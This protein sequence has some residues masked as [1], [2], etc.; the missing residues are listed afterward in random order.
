MHY[1]NLILDF[2]NTHAVWSYIIIFL[3]S[4]SE[5]LAI[6][7]LI[8]PGS[9]IMFGVG[10]IIAAGSLDVK[11][12]IIIA[13]TGAIVG[14]GISFWAGHYYKEKI[15]KIWPFSR[16]PGLLKRG[17]NFFHRHG[18]KSVLIGR[19]VGPVRPII[20]VIA[21]TMGM[22]PL[23]F[24]IINI[25]S[26]IG[27]AFAY[28][29]PG[30]IL[31][32]SIAVIG[33][34]SIRLAIIIVTIVFSMWI[35]FTISR[36]AY[37]FAENEMPKYIES[38]RQ[39]SSTYKISGNI[40]SPFKRFIFYLFR[41]HHGEETFLAMLILI[42]VLALWISLGIIQ[43]VLANDPIVQADK[44]VYHFFNSIRVRQI[45]HIF[46]AITEI[47]DSFINICITITVF[48]VL[49]IKRCFRTS[50]LWLISF[51]GALFLVQTLK[52]IMHLPRPIVL[53]QGASAYSFPS[54][55][56]T[57]SI[58]IFGFLC[59]LL[60]RNYHSAFKWLIFT[61]ALF[62]TFSIALSR[63]YLGVHWLS[64]VLGGFFIGTLWVALMGILY[65]K[66][67]YE[68]IPKKLLATITLSVFIIAGCWHINNNIK[69]D[70]VLYSLRKETKYTTFERWNTNDWSNL[71]VWRVDM[72][73]ER[74]QPLNF[75]F[76][77]EKSRLREYLLSKGW[78]KPEPIDFKSL[79]ETL[80]SKTS[81]QKLPVFPYLNS[82]EVESL[83]LVHYNGDMRTVFRMWDSDTNIMPDNITIYAGM[84][85]IQ[86]LHNFS[87]LLNLPK[88]THSYD[89]SLQFLKNDLT[90]HY[91][92]KK[93][94]RP[95]Y[96][97]YQDNNKLKWKGHILL[98][99]S[100]NQKNS[101][102]ENTKSKG[103]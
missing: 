8:M 28:I 9:T 80:S 25:I 4:F 52:W 86:Q 83:K 64:D 26:A 18:G 62:I 35:L 14:D 61:G 102:T 55:H 27:W 2:I 56:T 17:G 98:I 13:I 58:V 85:E 44:A 16:Y 5:S 100:D 40:L 3:V 1:I 76:A 73:G 43:D 34:I 101:I 74:E 90:D 19:F 32:A 49:I 21:G 51:A 42:F 63:L 22:S 30:I 37:N 75:Q 70:T 59:I 24:T 57:M 96:D 29:V 41:Q 36:K 78:K 39:W 53:Y 12:V 92:F 81:L 46:V 91:N 23:Y 7:G 38:L 20:P 97:G 48:L 47:G 45:D 10:A 103:N 79:L 50:V 31:G 88:D 6:V 93:V 69:K 99:W 87:W 94:T 68:K 67:P 54:G 89:A 84:V 71:P 15:N 77:G 60:I 33:T 66:Q 82:G 11:L 95:F 65:L 72:G